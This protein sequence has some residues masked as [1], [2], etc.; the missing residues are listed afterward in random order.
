MDKCPS[1]RGVHLIVVRPVEVFLLERH[2]SSAGTYESVRLRV[3]SVLWDVR[4]MRFYC[5]HHVSKQKMTIN[6]FILVFQKKR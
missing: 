3:V 5:I 4:F 2:L 6:K 1:Y